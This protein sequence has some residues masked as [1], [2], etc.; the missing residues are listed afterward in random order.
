MGSTR[1][2]FSFVHGCLLTVT[3][4]MSSG[5]QVENIP[6]IARARDKQ[7]CHASVQLGVVH[8]APELTEVAFDPSRP[9]SGK[10]EVDGSPV[11]FYVPAMRDQIPSSFSHRRRQ[12]FRFCAER[13]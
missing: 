3:H 5:E 10:R 4:S 1:G 13:V 7:A 6:N 8:I 2:C 12:A 11:P 9:S